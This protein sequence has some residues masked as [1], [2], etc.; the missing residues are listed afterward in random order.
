MPALVSGCQRNGRSQRSK[1]QAGKAS[2]RTYMAFAIRGSIK[3]NIY[4]LF[5]LCWFASCFLDVQCNRNRN[6]LHY[7]NLDLMYSTVNRK[8]WKRRK[9]KK[10]P[11]YRKLC[12]PCNCRSMKQML[13]WLK[14][15]RQL[16]KLLKKLLQSSKRFRLWFKIRRRSSH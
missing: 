10:L 13:V 3:G 7:M 14:R 11:N 16:R 15:E 5:F 1:R 9:V 12:K 8:T 2:G 6:K 4:L